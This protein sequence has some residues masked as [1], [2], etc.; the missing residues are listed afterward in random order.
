MLVVGILTTVH[1]LGHFIVARALH[2]KVLR[3]SI[4]FGRPMFTWFDRYGTEYVLAIVPFG[5]YVQLLGEKETPDLALSDL[6]RSFCYKPIWARM[7]VIV[8][9]AAFN[10]LFAVLMYWLVFMLGVTT[11]VPIIGDIPSGTI[12]HQAKLQTGQELIRIEDKTVDSWEDVS[13]TLM[14][15]AGSKNFINVST[16]DK[17]N[18]T[19]DHTLNLTSWDKNDAG[20]NILEALGIYPFD[21][22]S[23][24]V[25]KINQDTPASYANLLP[26]DKLLA[27]DGVSVDSRTQFKQYVKHK[28]NIPIELMV[29]RGDESLELRIT[30]VPRLIDG[31]E[32]V[33]Y[34]GIQFKSMPYP[35]EYTSTQK[36]APVKAMQLAVA[37]TKNFTILTYKLMGKMLTGKMSAKHVAGPVSIAKYA[38]QTV[39]TGL[40]PFLSFLAVVSISLAI[41]NMLPIPILDGGHFMLGVL[42]YIRK[43]PVTEATEELLNKLGLIILFS[44]MSLALYND[45]LRF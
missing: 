41:L 42:E 39:V 9:G 1:E 18:K 21:P 4:G 5:G 37:K 25:A 19:L 6:H 22:V 12:A 15:F 38:G 24:V 27:V 44:F 20:G 16:F 43:K 31:G 34:I 14:N 2:I 7:L 36:Y 30:P 32:E 40:Q 8:A 3:F 28:K 10:M 17:I 35:P 23:P 33:G 13:L 26:G 11:V 45:V 29:A